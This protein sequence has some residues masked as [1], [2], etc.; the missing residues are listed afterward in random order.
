MMRPGLLPPAPPGI[1]RGHRRTVDVCGR[2]RPLNGPKMEKQMSTVGRL[3][4]LPTPT[5]L[6]GIGR[7]RAR[8]SGPEMNLDPSCFSDASVSKI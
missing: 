7:G 3:P 4:S 1:G 6:P 5:S 2:G 8:H